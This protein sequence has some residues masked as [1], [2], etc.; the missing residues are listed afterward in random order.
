MKKTF[1]RKVMQWHHNQNKRTMPWKGEKEPYK[2]WISE[3]I[4]QQTRVMQGLSYYNNFIKEFPT[5]KSLALAPDEAVFK[6][7]EGLGYYSRC[8]NLLITARHIMNNLN[9]DFPK[10]HDKILALKGIGPYTAAAISSFAYGLPHAVVD[11]NVFR[12]LARFFG[13]TVP[14]DSSDGKVFFAKLAQE[15]LFREDSAGYNQAIMDFGATVCKPKLPECNACI[16][17]KLCIAHKRG[18]V[19]SLPVKE[20]QLVRKKRWFTYFIFLLDDQVFV[21]KRQKGDIWENLYEFYLLETNNEEEWKTEE[22]RKWLNNNMGISSFRI[23][24]ISKTFTQQLTHQNLQGRFITISLDEMPISLNHFKI[25]KQADLPAIPF[26]KFINQY[27]L[28][29][30]IA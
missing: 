21:N 14:I 12:V 5:V 22:I 6:A 2:I 29:Q 17:Q 11:G 27:L 9:G 13:E 18:L 7:W 10:T 8:K 4:L 16:L 28:N 15:L 1:T 3:I 20:K 19:N 24:N 25:V 30:E 26:P 23:N